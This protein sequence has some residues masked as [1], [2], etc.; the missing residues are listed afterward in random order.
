M[1]LAPFLD[2]LFATGE[3]KFTEPPEADDVRE[4][5]SVLR[6]AFA[7]FR[8]EVAGPP[9]N[10]DPEAATVAALFMARACWFVVSRDEPPEVVEASLEPIE[11]DWLESAPREATGV[12]PDEVLVLTD[13]GSEAMETDAFCPLTRPAI[14]HALP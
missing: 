2:H 14:R 10:F 5:Q 9:I 3:A 4:V 1:A 11:P 7:E 13:C 8:L 6:R 12:G